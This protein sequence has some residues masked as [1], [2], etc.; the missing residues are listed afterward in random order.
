MHAAGPGACSRLGGLSHD[1]GRGN[2]THYGGH[3]SGYQAK[4]HLHD[5]AFLLGGNAGRN[6]APVGHRR[7][8]DQPSTT[9]GH[10][11]L[12]LGLAGTCHTRYKA[13]EKG[14]ELGG[15]STPRDSEQLP[16]QRVGA[17]L[18]AA[19]RNAGV[20]LRE[21]ARLLRYGS[22]SSLSEYENGARMPSESVVQAYERLLQLK[23]GTLTAV[24]E[25]ANL[26]RH[27]D[28]WAKRRVHLPVQF[29][30]PPTG[31]SEYPRGALIGGGPPTPRATTVGGAAVTPASAFAE[32]P[33]VDGSDPDAAGCSPDAITVHA[34]RIARYS[35]HVVLGH[36]ELRYCA[37]AGAVWGRFEGYASLNHLA[38]R[39]RTVEIVIESERQTDG[40]R[41]GTREPYCFDLMWGN[42]LVADRGAFRAHVSVLLDGQMIAAG[43]TDFCLLSDHSQRWQ[44]VV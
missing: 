38:E 26:E 4:A 27:G 28:A 25:A 41:V 23:A 34:R 30:G 11:C 12:S 39:E 21:M 33:V 29:L 9:E 5:S 40:I 6:I 16:E 31:T 3:E 7:G 20:S 36:I 13:E 19:R 2:R 35:N 43:Q 44:P 8:E 42:L 24:L 10:V 18:R 17:V 22:H 15:R 32:E 14:E 1:H 37:R